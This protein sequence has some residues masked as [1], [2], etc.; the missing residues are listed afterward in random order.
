MKAVIKLQRGGRLHT[1][2]HTHIGSP[3]LDKMCSSY[4][5]SLEFC[6]LAQA[7]F[8]DFVCS[9]G[10]TE[11]FNSLSWRRNSC[12]ASSWTGKHCGHPNTNVVQNR[13][14][15]RELPLTSTDLDLV[16]VFCQPLNFPKIQSGKISNAHELNINRCRRNN[17]YQVAPPFPFSFPMPI[18][19]PI[20]FPT[21]GALSFHRTVCM[22]L[23][24]FVGG[25]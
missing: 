2:T 18:P 11:Y 17:R 10:Q 16:S 15:E 25:L 19:I 4:A 14:E 3:E 21:A 9:S 24:V 1:H 23:A 13:S 20:S 7:E 5:S 12:V 8:W 6:A 22:C